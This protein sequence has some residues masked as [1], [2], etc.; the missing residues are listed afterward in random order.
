MEYRKWRYEDVFQIAALE[1]ECAP[2]IEAGTFGDKHAAY[3]AAR[4]LFADD[5]LA[6]GNVFGAAALVR[7]VKLI[8]K[9]PNTKAKPPNPKRMFLL[10][11]FMLSSFP[12]LQCLH[13]LP[14]PNGL[15]RL[16]KIPLLG[17]PPLLP[18]LENLPV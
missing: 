14:F 18:Y 6:A 2:Y 15:P 12:R 4:Q 13:R 10:R 9:P 16:T 7:D 8:N 3:L 1:K 5:V 11:L 17:H